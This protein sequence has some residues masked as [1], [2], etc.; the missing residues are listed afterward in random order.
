[1]STT[2][3]DRSPGQVLCTSFGTP[4]AIGWLPV[5]GVDLGLQRCCLLAFPGSRTTTRPVRL[6]ISNR[7]ASCLNAGPEREGETL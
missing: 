3:Q 2:A 7:R 6:R 4:Q 5:A 1:M